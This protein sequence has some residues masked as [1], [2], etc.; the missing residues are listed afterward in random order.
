V[1]AAS[2]II[3]VVGILSFADSFAINE[4]GRRCAT[5]FGKSKWP[6]HIGCAMAG[7]ED[8]AAGLL[9]GAGALF[10]AWLAFDAIQEQLTEERQRRLR[11][12]SEAKATAVMGITQLVRMAA[13]T[14]WSIEQALKADDTAQLTAND[15]EIEWGESS[16]RVALDSLLVRE[17]V[18]DLS[19]EDRLLFISII[20]TMAT[21][22]TIFTK[23]TSN[24][25]RK[26]KLEYRRQ[27]LLRLHWYLS[28]FDAQLGKTFAEV[29]ETTPKMAGSRE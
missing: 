20:D 21:F 12:Q 23:T 29:S 22:V 13:A 25:D 8:L 24:V 28:D 16:M 10:A 11:Q 26:E 9:G 6:M 3:I 18:G 19:V 14:L 5:N 7:H 2:L 4:A 27:L 1:I 17:S 15:Q